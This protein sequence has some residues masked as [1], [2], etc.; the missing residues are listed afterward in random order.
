[1]IGLDTN[2][3]ARYFAQDDVVQSQAADA[4]IDSLTAEESG[5]ISQA[6][7]LELIWVFKSNFRTDRTGI[8]AI[9]D[10]LLSRNDII[11]ENLETT[12]QAL[13]IYRH[14]KADFADCLIACSGRAAGCAKTLTFDQ[15]AAQSAGMT[16]IQ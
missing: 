3:L 7:M 16:L 2:V 15:D 1:M 8:C 13:H 11:I 12:R 10:Y 14:G 9:L 6:A 4:V 5:W